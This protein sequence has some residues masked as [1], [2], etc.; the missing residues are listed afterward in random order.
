M[1]QR[2]S[3]EKSSSDEQLRVMDEAIADVDAGNFAS[4]ADIADED[5]LVIVGILYGAQ[6]RG[7]F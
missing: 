3:G 5:A 2:K 6:K 4:Y 1:S 7:H